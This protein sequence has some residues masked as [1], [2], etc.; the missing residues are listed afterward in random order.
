MNLI[1]IFVKIYYLVSICLENTDV[2]RV[3]P[4]LNSNLPKR[5]NPDVSI[6]K[7]NI[8]PDL[9]SRNE[10]NQDR[11]INSHVDLFRTFDST[12]F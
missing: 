5:P 11:K 8:T 4:T 6:G 10:C 2:S 12:E 9:C 7:A 1:S 3:R